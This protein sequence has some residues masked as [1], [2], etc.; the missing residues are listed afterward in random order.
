[1]KSLVSLV[2]SFNPT[3]IITRSGLRGTRGRVPQSAV[4]YGVEGALSQRDYIA[5]EPLIARGDRNL[6]LAVIGSRV[7]GI[8][9]RLELF[10]W[11]RKALF[12]RWG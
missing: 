10:Y 7:P 2:V 11:L 4:Y 12:V 3:L 8:S 1:M 9:K 5:L 6:N